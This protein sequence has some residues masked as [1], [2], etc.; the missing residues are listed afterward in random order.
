MSIRTRVIISFLAVALVPLLAAGAVFYFV[1]TRIV[2]DQ[3]LRQLESIAAI[4][5]NRIENALH[6]NGEFVDHV[7]SRVLLNRALASYSA[8]PSE[9]ARREMTASLQSALESDHSFTRVY[10]AAPDGTVI[11]STDPGLVGKSLATKDFFERGKDSV[12]VGEF[13]RSPEGDLMEYLSGPVK[14]GN[15]LLGVL[16][17]ESEASNVSDVVRDY[18]GLGATGET[19]IAIPTAEGDAIYLAPTRFG[20]HGPLTYVVPKSKNLPINVALEGRDEVL[21]GSPDYRDQPVLAVTR[22]LDDPRLGIVVKIDRSEAFAPINLLSF[23]LLFML[24]GAALLVVLTSLAVSGSITRP[25]AELTSVAGEIAAGDLTRRADMDRHDEVG[26][27]ATAFNRMTDDL[28]GERENLER[29]VA[30]RTEELARS[31]M[32]LDGYAHAV[33]HDL[34]GPLSAIS[35]AAAEL[36]SMLEEVDDTLLREEGPEALE[37][38]SRSLDRAFGLTEDLLV[39]AEAGH[40]PARVEVV[41]VSASVERACED[42]AA[43]IGAKSARVEV[44]EDLGHVV[45]NQTHIYQLFLNLISNAIKH[46]D[47][48]EPLVRV[49]RLADDGDALKFQVC[50]NGPGIPSGEFDRIFEPFFKGRGGET[51][52][53]LATVKKVVLMYRGGITASNEKDG[54]ACFE[55]T[56]R[57][58]RGEPDAAGRPGAPG[59]PSSTGI[60]PRPKK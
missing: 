13:F 1:G 3:A 36:S 41:D 38:L 25:I 11:A 39:L 14:N 60:A 16:V 27:L 19:V 52:I 59:R 53:G 56:L 50:D 2:R 51:G 58:Y 55:F 37:Q 42:L 5:K 35:L 21:A 6:N 15:D 32:E 29:K 12:D 40:K 43:K 24:L 48:P 28:V 54:G 26:A 10:V 4:Q 34:R 45:A 7:L 46:N 30:E 17:I 31:N 18:A 44:D 49:K 57:N 8:A 9:A 20:G 23:V 33:S 47:L 22:H